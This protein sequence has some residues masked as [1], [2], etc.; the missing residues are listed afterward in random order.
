MPTA[1]FCRVDNWFGIGKELSSMFLALGEVCAL[2]SVLY[3]I[4]QRGKL[5][6]FLLV[7]MNHLHFWTTVAIV[8]L[9]L[10]YSQLASGIVGGAYVRYPALRARQSSVIGVAIAFAL[11]GVLIS[12]INFA[13]AASRRRSNQS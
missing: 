10:Y 2:D 13:Q 9:L 6:P 3:W 8:P 1:F 7:W 12:I 5:G 11:V 4:V